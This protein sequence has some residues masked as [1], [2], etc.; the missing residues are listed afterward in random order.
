MERDNENHSVSVNPTESTK[1]TQS[2]PFLK[3]PGY[4]MMSV[5]VTKELPLVKRSNAADKILWTLHSTAKTCG[6]IS[7][8]KRYQ[9]KTEI[10]YP[11]KG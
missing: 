11:E 10:G 5:L 7:K 6:C 8:E 4:A 3:S 2:R 9:Q 1:W